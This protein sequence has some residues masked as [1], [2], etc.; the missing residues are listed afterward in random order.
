[1]QVVR[2]HDLLIHEIL[3]RFVQSLRRRVA[4]E[5]LQRCIGQIQPVGLKFFLF[6]YE[7][8]KVIL[9][10]LCVIMREVVPVKVLMLIILIKLLITIM[11]K[12]NE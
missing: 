2:L 9:S 1:M 6:A 8:P 7:R 3:D 11:V 12:L 4:F 5:P 10:W